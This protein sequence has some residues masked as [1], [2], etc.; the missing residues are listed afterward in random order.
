MT[1]ADV[2][3]RALCVSGVLAHY[4]PQ[5][6]KAQGCAGEA[7]KRK[8]WASV[9]AAGTTKRLLK[10]GSRKVRFLPGHDKNFFYSFVTLYPYMPP[11][12]HAGTPQGRPQPLRS[13]FPTGEAE[14]GKAGR[15]QTF[16]GAGGR[17]QSSRASATGDRP[18]PVHASP[19]I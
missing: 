19:R 11:P 1:L 16:Q 7:F 14:K 13:H 10:N 18:G 8:A 5:V 2:K 6:R 17:R 9:R 3:T 15:I 4:A 12:D